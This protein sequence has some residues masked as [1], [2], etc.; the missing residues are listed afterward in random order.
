M[1]ALAVDVVVVVLLLV[2]IVVEV[3]M[4]RPLVDGTA[5]LSLLL[6]SGYVTKSVYVHGYE[7]RLT[8]DD[9]AG[10][11]VIMK[12]KSPVGGLLPTVNPPP[13]VGATMMLG[14]NTGN[15]P[16]SNFVNVDPIVPL[17][18]VVAEMEN[19]TVAVDASMLSV[20]WVHVNL[21]PGWNVLQREQRGNREK[22]KVVADEG[23]RV[24]RTSSWTANFSHATRLEDFQ[25]YRYL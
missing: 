13:D 12:V 21:D 14:D 7:T 20:I 23:V 10:A 2:S 22:R 5:E 11:L 15:V 24:L 3:V 6:M 18:V 8:V 19:H 17:I 9:G 1:L 4:P 16:Q 25:K